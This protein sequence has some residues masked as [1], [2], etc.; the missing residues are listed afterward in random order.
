[1]PFGRLETLMAKDVLDLLHLQAMLVE[2]GATRMSGQMP[3]QMLSDTSSCSHL[4][5]QPIT[6]TVVTDIGEGLDRRISLDDGHGPASKD[7]AQRDP[8]H[9]ASLQLIDS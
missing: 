4:T 7:I 5:Q 1:M 2:Q 6:V 8:H 9:M 3:V